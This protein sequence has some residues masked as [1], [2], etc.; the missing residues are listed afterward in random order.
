MK[1]K[2]ILIFSLLIMVI[3]IT[4]CKNSNGLIIGSKSSVADSLNN[5]VLLTIDES[6]LSNTGVTI[7][8]TNYNENSLK[9]GE[10][11][12]IEIKE[13]NKWHEIN[14]EDVFITALYSLH[15]GDTEEYEIDWSHSYGKLPK[16]EYRLI[17]YFYFEDKD[18]KKS[19]EFP[20][21]VEF[22]I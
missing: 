3:C 13:K 7:K 18:N 14:V 8:I 21:F 2:F 4:G 1:S 12:S 16:G 10:G 11:Y 9:Y 22:S 19:K 6:T 15:K 20:V 5:G 17:K